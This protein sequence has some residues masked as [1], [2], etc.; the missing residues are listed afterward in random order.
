MNVSDEL[1]KRSTRTQNKMHK[2]EINRKTQKLKTRLRPEGK[3]KEDKQT[4]TQR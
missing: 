2:E 4:Y 1:R 3:I